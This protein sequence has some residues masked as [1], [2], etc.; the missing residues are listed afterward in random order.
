MDIGTSAKASPGWSMAT[1]KASG[2]AELNGMRNGLRALD[3][4]E[5]SM[6]VGIRNI[7]KGCCPCSSVVRLQ[8]FND[9]DMRR[10]QADQ[11]RFSS[12][13]KS[14]TWIFGI[15]PVGFDDEL[16]SILDDPGILE[17]KLVDKVVKRGSKMVNNGAHQNCRFE[18]DSRKVEASDP[19]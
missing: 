17:G 5:F 10:A 6:L 16:C 18:R 2:L 7:P 15:G 14:T 9:G 1:F 4:S 11:L 8:A 3:D 19:A 12:T 13:I